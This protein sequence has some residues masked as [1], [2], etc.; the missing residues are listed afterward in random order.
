MTSIC[1]SSSIWLVKMHF[2]TTLRS[3]RHEKIK[4]CIFW[5]IALISWLHPKL[6]SI[7]TVKLHFRVRRDVM[8]SSS[9]K[10]K[11]FLKMPFLLTSIIFIVFRKWR[12]KFRSIFN[13]NILCN[14]GYGEFIKCPQSSGTSLESF[15]FKSFKGRCTGNWIIYGK[16]WAIY[17]LWYRRVKRVHFINKSFSLV[18]FSRNWDINAIHH[19]SFTFRVTFWALL[20][21]K[22]HDNNVQKSET[23]KVKEAW[24][25][26][27]LHDHKFINLY[28]WPGNLFL[29]QNWNPC[30]DPKF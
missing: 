5:N 7:W 15:L 18:Y 27:F 12:Q 26:L 6:T 17:I 25:R 30:P 13:L 1:H 8:T 14:G 10:K 23:R 28:S 24:K 29:P 3:H 19:V 21:L 4:S 11:C 16:P 9:L 2:C 20:S 22:N